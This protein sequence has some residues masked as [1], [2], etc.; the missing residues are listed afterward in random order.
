[1]GGGRGRLP[2]LGLLI[3]IFAI[4]GVTAA[5]HT[6]QSAQGRSLQPF[7]LT[8]WARAGVLRTAR[9]KHTATLLRD[10]RV[11]VAG[12]DNSNGQYL[13]SV[14]FYDPRRNTWSLGPSMLT[15][16]H[17]QTATL[18]DDGR[19]LLVGGE[20]ALSEAIMTGQSAPTTP[21]WPP[22]AEIYDPRTNRWA[23]TAPM[24]TARY[25]QTAVLLHDGRVLVIGGHA[26]DTT[27]SDSALASAEM[28]DPRRN[29]WLPA[30]SVPGG[31]FDLQAVA[32]PDDNVLVPGGD[33][34]RDFSNPGLTSAALYDASTNRWT[35]TGM[36][37]MRHWGETSTLLA[38]G[39]VLVVSA[40]SCQ[41][42]TIARSG[43]LYDP[44]TG[45][46]HIS[47]PV[48][49]NRIYHTATVVSDGRVLFAGGLSGPDANEYPS[50]LVDLYDPMTNR[51]T[52][53]PPLR[54]GREYHTATLL[55]DGRVLIVGGE[56]RS[57]NAVSATVLAAAEISQ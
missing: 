37:H 13:S 26:I 29:L 51:W 17:E 52:A 56:T 55:S 41:A 54:I 18:L 16:R 43:E 53:G 11:L 44:R 3:V 15:T 46:W 33:D 30:G 49:H 24:A 50:R 21:V 2:G 57:P 23:A 14:E 36:L 32:L 8:G 7:H 27:Q 25:G 34:G 20:P 5:R 35:H 48:P 28:Y 4:A 19:V 22:T 6:H 42:K 9:E 47:A 40:C 38:T 1:M 39:Q 31:R 12:G 10:G 45:R